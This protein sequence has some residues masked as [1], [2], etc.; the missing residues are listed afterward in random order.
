MRGKRIGK[1]DFQHADLGIHM[2]EQIADARRRKRF[3][4]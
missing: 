2:S 3:A 4:A 1:R